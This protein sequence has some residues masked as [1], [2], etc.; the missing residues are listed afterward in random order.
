[1]SILNFHSKSRWQKLRSRRLRKDGYKCR[2]CARYGR[3]VKATTVH[4]IF[5]IETHWDLRYNILNLISLCNKCHERMH[6]RMTR[7]ITEVGIRWQKQIENEIF[8]NPPSKT[9]G[10]YDLLERKSATASNREHF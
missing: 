5:P 10:S 2:E 7:A 9:V 6:H 3:T 1:M 8:T 4:H